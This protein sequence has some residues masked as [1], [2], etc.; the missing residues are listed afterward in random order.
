MAWWSPLRWLGRYTEVRQA[1]ADRGRVADQ[2]EN[3][4]TPAALLAGQQVDEERLA[5][6]L[7][8][9][10][11]L[12]S[13]PLPFLVRVLCGGVWCRMFDGAV[14]ARYDLVALGGGGSEYP[15]VGQHVP[16]RRRYLG[17]EPGEKG[18]RIEDDG[19]LAVAPE[20][21]SLSRATV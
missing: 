15:V 19:G 12:W 11:S 8:P 5:D 4:S 9:R 2:A 16:S 18:Y 3:P 14:G 17:G 21:A 13:N 10:E 7:G 20:S 6:E 1:S